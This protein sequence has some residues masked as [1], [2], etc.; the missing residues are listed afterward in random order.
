MK[1]PEVVKGEA[2][3]MPLLDRVRGY[4]F[5]QL[6]RLDEAREALHWSLAGAREREQPLDVALTIAALVEFERHRGGTIDLALA[7]ESE[8]ILNDL[9][10][11]SVPEVPTVVG[12]S[13]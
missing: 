11:E 8:R 12:T 10:V 3:Q 5:W 9:G 1:Q 6:G 13:S 7:E 4:A 2:V